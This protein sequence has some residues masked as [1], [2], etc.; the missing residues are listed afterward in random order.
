[1]MT[2]TVN[3]PMAITDIVLRRGNTGNE[4]KGLQTVLNYRGADLEVDGIFGPNTET[5]VLEF[6][7]GVEISVDGIVG[8]NTW[9]SLRAG[10]VI[11]RSA[12]R[13]ISLRATADPKATVLQTLKSGAIIRVLGRS[14]IL[15]EDYRWFQVQAQQHIGWVREDAIR[16]FNPFILPLPAVAGVTLRMRPRPWLMEI[17]P[18]IE[19][20]IRSALT[21]SFRDRV[22]YLFQ[23]LDQNGM[24]PMGVM[25]VYLYGGPV[26][27]SGGCT[28]LVL[29]MTDKGYR[30]MSRIPTVQQPVIISE[31]RTNGYPDLI[32]YTAGGRLA[33]AYRR[34]R[35]NGIDYPNNPALALALPAG[36]AV[37]GFA[38]ASRIT[39]DLA[40]PLVEV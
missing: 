13:G 19:A 40:A 12:Q 20:G 38:F 35:F 24:G 30:V 28:L 2:A 3:H 5:R 21:L 39:P 36:T 26:C 29:E 6:Q 4:V 11:A 32:V 17:E 9:A 18:M 1:M 33:P 31:Q 22:R 37:N 34:L 16:L 15:A 23:S 14:P 27:G 25:L 7:R 10:R 8:P